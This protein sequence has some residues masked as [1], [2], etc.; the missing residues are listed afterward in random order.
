MQKV[1]RLGWAVGLSLK[2]YGL[3]IGVRANNPAGLERVCQHLPAGWEAST[4]TVVDRLYSIIVGGQ[5]SR[6][7][8]R[9]FNLLYGDH[10]RLARSIELDELFESFESDLRL[11]VAEF[12]P[13]RV[14]VHA[15]VVG[16]QGRAIVVPG[17]SLAG[18]STLVSELVKAGATYYSDEYAVFDP[19]GRVHPFHKPLEMRDSMTYRQTKVRV[20]EI[21]GQ[22]GS[23]PLPVSL[24]LLTQYK[25]VMK[26]R[27]RELSAGEGVLGLLANTVSARRDPERAF[28]TLQ[29][30]V[31]RARVLKGARP[32]ARHVV[33]RV[34]RL[35]ER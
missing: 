25:D 29:H 20:E 27:P 22:S 21:G 17:R 15:G 6:P 5:G 34:L 26:W 32:D 23:K 16:W 4:A 24:V 33:E 31:A 2:T 7:G 35:S 19:R 8:L 14:F 18:K 10:V 28:A 11:R 9:R 12:A 13:R 1:D 3:R 30:V